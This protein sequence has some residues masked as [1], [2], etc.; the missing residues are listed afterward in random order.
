MIDV[1]PPFVEASFDIEFVSFSVHKWM[2]NRVLKQH[3]RAVT[4][5][6]IFRDKD[7]KPENT[8]LINALTNENYAKPA[9]K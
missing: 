3:S 7:L 9:W 1:S 6:V 5:W 2:K 4:I 8:L